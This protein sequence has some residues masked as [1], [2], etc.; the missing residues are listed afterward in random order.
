[1]FG[2]DIYW[3]GVQ[4]ISLLESGK[5][6]SPDNSPVFH[7]VAFLFRIFGVSDETLLF[8]QILTSVWLITSLFFARYL[9]FSV[10]EIP[11]Q[12]INF[13]PSI[14]VFVLG[15]LYPKQSW[16]LGFLILSFGFSFPI[17]TIS[18]LF[19]TTSLSTSL[20]PSFSFPSSSL[21]RFRRRWFSSGLF[22][23]FAF[24]FHP[25]VALLGLGVLVLYQIPEKFYPV[26]FCFVC[27]LPFFLPEDPSG[28]FYSDK[29]MFPLS[30]A[31]ALAGLGILWDWG[32]LVFGRSELRFKKMRRA[33]AFFGFL[34]I[35]PIFHFAD[36]QYR[37]LL[38]LILLTQIF[39]QWNV[40]QILVW[41]V[42]T[43]LWIFTMFTNPTSFRYS[44][45]QMWI[46]GESMASVPNNGLLIAHH[47]FCEYYHFQFR[48]D[49]L[50]FEPDTKAI[51]ELPQGTEIYR[52]VY[53]I[54]YENLLASKDENKIP[55]FSSIQ[56]LGEYQ[57]VLEKDWKR[58]RT[59]L[60]KRNS[61]LLSIANS[62]KN[63]YKER[64]DFIK[65][66]HSNGL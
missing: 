54:R 57:L 56:P 12:R 52:A 43:G 10:I 33:F 16:A 9:I 2:K 4:A 59:W 62:W 6:H 18:S 14:L 50:S 39:I 30:A 27:L 49:C 31:F 3:Y 13:I 63:P 15:F 20:K 28:R 11:Y 35:L 23:I 66:K 17:R 65:R 24:W 19:A 34:L 22:F 61:K 1:M 7:I 44:Y 58:Y 64:P 51:S 40:F 41:T 37:I 8:F 55:F 29:A 48:K 60:E 53:G 38:S 45:E 21:F 36:I 42:S 32:F 26:F 25:M 46:P 47:G 5:L